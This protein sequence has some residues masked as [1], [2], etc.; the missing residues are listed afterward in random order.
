LIENAT[1]R[2][3]PCGPMMSTRDPP[4]NGSA[5]IHAS[6]AADVLTARHDSGFD[7]FAAVAG[8]AFDIE[9]GPRHERQF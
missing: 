3:N 9:H 6:R 4:L 8:D 2:W 7:A 1:V 5:A